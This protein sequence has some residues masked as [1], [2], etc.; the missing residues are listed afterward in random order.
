MDSMKFFIADIGYVGLN[1]FQA[2]GILRHQIDF[3]RIPW[4]KTNLKAYKQLKTLLKETH[5]DI[6]HCHTPMGGV[7][8]R[9]TVKKYRKTGPKVIYTAHGFHFF[10]GTLLKNG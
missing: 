3:A 8:A 9:M 7:W 6:V 1:D 2:D 5:F 4:S 10:K